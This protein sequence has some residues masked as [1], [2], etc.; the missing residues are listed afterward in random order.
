VL[1]PNQYSFSERH[2]A[3]HGR[4]VTVNSF[5]HAFRKVDA[6]LCPLCGKPN[7]CQ[8]AAFARKGSCWC[9]KEN[10][11]DELLAQVPTEVRNK[12]C[13]CRACVTAFS[14]A[15]VGQSFQPSELTAS[16]TCVVEEAHSTTIAEP[17]EFYSD[18][19]PVFTAAYYLRCSVGCDSAC[20][21]YP[22]PPLG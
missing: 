14:R 19:L 13:V 22:N 4:E 9:M 10:I 2:I 15:L 6:N 7:D 12:A 20:R 16:G 5:R 8:R 1:N 17:G 18:G 21:H 11:A 3:M